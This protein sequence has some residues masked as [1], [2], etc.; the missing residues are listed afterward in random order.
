MMFLKLFALNVVVICAFELLIHVRKRKENC[1][2]WS[3]GIVVIAISLGAVVYQI[4]S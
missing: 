2:L 4:M 3:I 1:E